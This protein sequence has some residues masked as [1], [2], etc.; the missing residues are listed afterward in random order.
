MPF[1]GR[2]GVFLLRKVP[3]ARGTE[4]RRS[5]NQE[6]GLRKCDVGDLEDTEQ[7]RASA[8]CLLLGV[9]VYSF[10]KEDRPCR[11]PLGAQ[12]PRFL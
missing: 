10:G 9:C 7:R 5:E 4:S 2:D 6:T 11:D 3:F 8:S 12:G 1:H